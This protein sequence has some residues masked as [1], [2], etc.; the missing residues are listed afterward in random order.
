M[1]A[2]RII[3]DRGEFVDVLAR[4]R[5]GHVLVRTGESS[6]SVVIDGGVVWHSF[7]TL[8]QYGLIDEFDNPHG[9][10]CAQYYRISDRGRDFAE[11]ACAAWRTRPLL[12]RLATR[13]AG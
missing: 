9:F 6:G 4:L 12:Q 5:R 7:P 8:A 3:P 10:P 11:R 2:Q 13:L 1:T